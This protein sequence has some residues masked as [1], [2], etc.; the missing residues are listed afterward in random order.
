MEVCS[1]LVHR[2]AARRLVL[3]LKYEGCREAAEVLA[4]M[5]ARLVPSDARALVPIPRIYLRRVRFGSDPAL[6]LARALSRRCGLAVS[7]DL[8]PRILGGA[9]AGL[10]RASRKVSFRRRG[11]P[12]RGV[13]LVDDVITTGMTLQTAV[14][15]LGGPRVRAAVTATMSL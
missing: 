7:Q 11:V 4:A 1:A 15:T 12:P 2:G 14:E 9:N 6:L 8:G 13:V 3:R 10:G 5:M